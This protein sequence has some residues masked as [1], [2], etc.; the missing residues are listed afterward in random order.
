MEIRVLRYFLAV[1]REETISRAAEVL[2]ITQPTLSRQLAELEEEL[3]TQLFM[4][5]KRKISLTDAGMLLRRRAED[6]VEL[7][8]KTE[9]ELIGS[10]QEL[11]GLISIGSAVSCAAQIWPRLIGSFR[12]QYPL[13]RYDLMFGNADQIK[14]R[15]DRG[16]IDVA[17]LIEPVEIE[18]YE[19]LRLR[20]QETWG[21]LMRRDEPLAQKAFIS[22]EDLGSLPLM[23]SKRN[24]VQNAF[25]GWFGDGFDKLNIFLTYNLLENAVQLVEEGI[26]YAITI[27]GAV[28]ENSSQSLCFR[29]FHPRLTNTS[30]LVWK[31]YQAV[32]AATAA[33]I[34]EA[35]MLVEHDKL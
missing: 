17:L 9:Q 18:K 16:L 25:A 6:I 30:V 34:E 14:E 35:K 23:M 11:G 15:I 31:K 29:P 32:D 28:N 3:G 22:P 27:E 5:G 12:R 19:F 1:V 21:L 4:R 7:A 20:Q 8:D 33:F 13:V 26:G 24:L 2:H 10:A